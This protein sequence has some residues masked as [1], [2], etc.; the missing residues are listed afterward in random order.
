MNETTEK[1]SHA[2]YARTIL[3]VSIF[4]VKYDS[5]IT[6]N[7]AILT[8][9]KLRFKITR[10]YNAITW[11]LKG[12]ADLMTSNI[13][14]VTFYSKEK[15][16]TTISDDVIWQL[17]STSE[18][19]WSKIVRKIVSALMSQSYRLLSDFLKFSQSLKITEKVAFNIA[20]EA[21]YVYIFSRQKLIKNA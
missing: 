14:N 15:N 13:A 21:S 19:A 16:W 20:S 8:A 6:E 18:K 10:N 2:R 11:F 9:L 12:L 3:Q 4:M 7:P 17:K 1:Y 5:V